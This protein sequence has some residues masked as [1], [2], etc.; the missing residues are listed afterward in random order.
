[1]DSPA[2]IAY[3]NWN[4]GS[5]A[6]F[7]LL[8]KAIKAE[9]AL[10][11]M[12]SNVIHIAT[13]NSIPAGLDCTEVQVLIVDSAVSGLWHHF[14]S[15]QLICTAWAGVD[16]IVKDASFPREIP[17]IRLVDPLLTKRMGQ[18]AL[19]HVLAFHRDM[20]LF[21]G[22]QRLKVWDKKPR[23]L[24]KPMSECRVGVLGM[25]V[26]GKETAVQ[27]VRNGFTNVV[28][29]GTSE[30]SFVVQSLVDQEDGCVKIVEN[31]VRVGAGREAL[32][33]LMEECEV[34]INL[35]PST[36]D[37]RRLI[38]F[39]VLS[40]MRQRGS[41]FM[42]F[43]RGATVVE[44][45]VVA[46]LDDKSIGLSLAILDVFE[47]EPLPVES[48]LWTHERVVVTPHMAALTEYSSAAATVARTLGMFYSGKREI[49]GCVDFAKGF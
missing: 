34:V 45:D 36:P 41:V 48:V 13:N 20:H 38:D 42:N 2:T 21:A 5:N 19:T 14:P 15:L 32:L 3:I 10:Q 23:G 24:P 8:Q 30:R 16:K 6:S 43:G 47:V 9:P 22:Q 37:T 33:R 17:L 49:P 28:G 7:D 12:S 27:L 18:T 40:H 26:L 39:E 4:P 35:L 31:M 1:M 44:S 11:T 46:A 25:G 29:W